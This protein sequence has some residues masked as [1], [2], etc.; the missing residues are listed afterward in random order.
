MQDQIIDAE[1]Q[2]AYNKFD[3]MRLKSD[4]TTN[5]FAGQKFFDK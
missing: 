4:L 2:Q 5:K 1:N 3:Y